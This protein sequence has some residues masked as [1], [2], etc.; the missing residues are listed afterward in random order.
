MLNGRSILRHNQINSTPK[1]NPKPSWKRFH[2][3]G[4]KLFNIRQ[5]IIALL[6]YLKNID[7][8]LLCLISF[9]YRSMKCLSFDF[10]LILVVRKVVSKILD[11]PSTV[12][13]NVNFSWKGLFCSYLS[14]TSYLKYVTVQSNYMHST[15][16][17]MPFSRL[18]RLSIVT[19]NV[20]ITNDTALRMLEHNKPCTANREY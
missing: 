19:I 13:I 9:Q 8:F 10:L 6:H 14:V 20:F 1:L 12:R 11:Y 17:T 7:Y 3:W 16:K 5:S 15:K 2:Y 18:R 4:F